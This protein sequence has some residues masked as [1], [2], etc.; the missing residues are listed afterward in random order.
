MSKMWDW[1]I[2]SGTLKHI[3]R[4]HIRLDGD[5]YW[6]LNPQDS[7]KVKRRVYPTLRLIYSWVLEEEKVKVMTNKDLM[8]ELIMYM[9][10]DHQD[11]YN[12]CMLRYQ[13][14]QSIL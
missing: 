13:K 11:F 6:G 5:N 2:I 3:F 10:T 9:K 8:F 1:E 4:K 7:D 12:Q 14:L